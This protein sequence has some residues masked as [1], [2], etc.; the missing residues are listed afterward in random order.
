M[1]KSRRKGRYHVFLAVLPDG[2]RPIDPADVPESFGRASV[3]GRGLTLC[4]A[5]AAAREANA[6]ALQASSAPRL[7]SLVVIGPKPGKAGA[8]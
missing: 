5:I 8:A 6:A 7:W 1:S 4:Q 3:E 2:D